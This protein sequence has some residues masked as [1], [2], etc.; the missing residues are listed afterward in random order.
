[1]LRAALLLTGCIALAADVGL[2]PRPTLGD[3]P[4]RV[5]RGDLGLGA[6]M[7][8]PDEVGSNFASDLN[9]AYVVVEVGI[10]PYGAGL[11]V[12][13][14]SFLLR[15]GGQMLRP[16]EPRTIAA[17]LQKRSTSS[18]SD[19]G[20]YPNVG[21][22]YESGSRGYDPVTG[23]TRGGGVT[24]STGVTVASGGRGPAPGST[25]ADR[26]TMTTE[27]REKSLPEGKTTTPVAGYL[28]FPAPKAKGVA[29][30]LEFA[31]PEGNTRLAIPAAG[32]RKKKH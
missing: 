19:I 9:R 28:Y 30:E 5:E 4:A 12:K 2:K 32:H 14:N 25:N 8:S 1:M 10:Y 11:D 24:T 29:Y 20:I 26:D 7:L 18:A 17:V 23:R 3:Y 27:L 16:A 21:I 13:H 6:A 15:A 31:G 22:G